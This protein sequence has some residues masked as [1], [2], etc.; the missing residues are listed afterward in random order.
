MSAYDRLP[1]PARRIAPA[2]LDR[3]IRTFGKTQLIQQQP[4]HFLKLFD[5]QPVPASWFSRGCDEAADQLTMYSLVGGGRPARLWIG[6]ESAAAQ[7]PV[8]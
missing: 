6:I 7:H 5:R 1:Q 8:G 4:N 3:W 2:S